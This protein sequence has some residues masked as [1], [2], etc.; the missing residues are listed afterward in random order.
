MTVLSLLIHQE[1]IQLA[2]QE[3][4]GEPRLPWNFEPY[5]E[6]YWTITAQ[7]DILAWRVDEEEGCFH[8]V[9]EMKRYSLSTWTPDV[10]RADNFTALVVHTTNGVVACVFA[11]EKFFEVDN[12]WDKEKIISHCESTL[13]KM[14]G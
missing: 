3:A 11:D 2:L 14:L 12:R 10:M 4:F 7:G 8:E 13:E 5:L 1:S 9:Y 6:Y